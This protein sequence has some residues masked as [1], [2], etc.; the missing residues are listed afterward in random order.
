MITQ[1]NLLNSLGTISGRQWQFGEP[2]RYTGNLVDLKKL[3]LLPKLSA[4]FLKQLATREWWL[5]P[6]V[7]L[8]PATYKWEDSIKHLICTTT[9]SIF[10]LKPKMPLWSEVF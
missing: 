4:K 6:I 7:Y 5:R 9:L 3:L 8:Q 10:S 1:R 2:Q